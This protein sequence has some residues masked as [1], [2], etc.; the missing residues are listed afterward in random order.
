MQV[1][2]CKSK[3]VFASRYLKEVS[4]TQ[5]NMGSPSRRAPR[6]GSLAPPSE[7]SLYQHEGASGSS[8]RPSGLRTS[9]RGHV[10]SAVLRQ[11]HHSSLS[12]SVGRDVFVHPELHGQEGSPLGRESLHSSPS[13]VHHGVVQRHRRRPK[14]SQSGDRVR[15]DPSPGGSRS[16]GPQVASYDRSLRNLLDS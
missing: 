7:S 8:A 16:A 1:A 10:G 9:D 4:A 6:L 13:P 2:T 3:R 14:S 15:M 11:H 5:D 12:S